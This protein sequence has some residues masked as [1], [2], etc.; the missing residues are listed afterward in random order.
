MGPRRAIERRKRLRKRTTYSRN[1]DADRANDPRQVR[2]CGLLASG[3]C[4]GITAG[5]AGEGGGGAAGEQAAEDGS[6]DHDEGFGWGGWME[7]KA[8]DLGMWMKRVGMEWGMVK[9]AVDGFWPGGDW[10]NMTQ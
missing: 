8:I 7:M 1:G 10:K 6:G 9:T 3:G 2:G 4:A 5:G